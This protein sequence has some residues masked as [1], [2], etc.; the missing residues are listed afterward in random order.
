[1]QPW[2]ISSVSE[3]HSGNDLLEMAVDPEKLWTGPITETAGVN[4]NWLSSA[5][6]ET[7]PGLKYWPIAFT[8]CG[9]TQGLAFC[10]TLPLLHGNQ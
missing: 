6:C 8:C 3:L 2:R 4:P 10:T 5:G 9:M 7:H 1:M